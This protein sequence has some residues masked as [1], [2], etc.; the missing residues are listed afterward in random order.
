M[1]GNS[2][3]L[4][5]SIIYLQVRL[6]TWKAGNKD[7]MRNDLSIFLTIILSVLIAI[8]LFGC[9]NGSSNEGRTDEDIQVLKWLNEPDDPLRPQ[10]YEKRYFAELSHA[11]EAKQTVYLEY[12]GTKETTQRQV[13]PE[14]LFRRGEY[15]Y[16]EAFCL[17]R[18]EYRRFRLD[19]IKY[20]RV[21]PNSSIGVGSHRYS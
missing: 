9:G 6:P 5:K 1:P 11:I 15:I 14:R 21:E 8:F 18:N 2:A 12:A 20:L 7:I 13:R 16:V 19:R 3:K 4:T 10:D 17:L